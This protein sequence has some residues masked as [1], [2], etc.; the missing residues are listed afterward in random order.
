VVVVGAGIAGL[1]C[2]REL[3]SRGL[4]TV[5]LEARDRAGGRIET[6]RVW[7]GVSLDLGAAWIYGFSSNPILDLANQLKTRMV[8]VDYG[9]DILFGPDGTA[10]SDTDEAVVDGTFHDVMKAVGALRDARLAAGQTDMSLAEA[11]RTVATQ[12]GLDAARLRALDYSVNVSLEHEYA[13]DAE[14]LSL[15]HWD[16]C[17]CPGDRVGNDVLLPDGYGAL[18]DAL[19]AVL[20]IR[21]GTR[22]DRIV[23]SATGVAVETTQG[24]FAGQRAVVTIPIGV[25]KKSPPRFDPPL[26]QAKLDA[27]GRL[28]MD[29]LDK[30]YL[31]FPT[32]FWSTPGVQLFNY[33]SP[34]R[35]QWGETYDYQRVVGAPILLCFNA[36]SFAHHLEALTDDL[37]V[38][39]AM[40]AVRRIWP[41]APDPTDHLCTRW[42]LDPF[43][44]GSY[45]HLPPGA[46]GADYQA[47]AAPVGDQLF[48]AGEGTSIEDPGTVRG[49]YLSGVREA[50]RIAA[51]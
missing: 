28:G 22:V 12:K 50:R 8:P 35:G 26:P 11:I 23:H 38:A 6:T 37:V 25:L 3:V 47:M 17:V 19:A 33:I 44:R 32:A 49:A 20:D 27:L 39:E 46:S 29:V 21:V 4:T 31:R 9:A 24:T 51:L 18:V 7:P 2:A 1:A 45:S 48:F 34:Q 16:D 15:L 42:G 43:A 41:G 36:G 13:A 5:V 40:A 10:L 14:D 30:V